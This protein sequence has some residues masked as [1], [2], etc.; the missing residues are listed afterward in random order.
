M[1]VSPVTCCFIESV[2]TYD[3]QNLLKSG[4]KHQLLSLGLSVFLQ[5]R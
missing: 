2:I 1:V 5:T 4:E 3:D